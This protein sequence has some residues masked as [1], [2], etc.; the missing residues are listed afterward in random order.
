MRHSLHLPK[1]DLCK[2]DGAG[3]SAW[4]VMLSQSEKMCLAAYGQQWGQG[5]ILLQSPGSPFGTPKPGSGRIVLVRTGAAEGHRE[6]L[7]LGVK[8]DP[9]S[10][11]GR[12][13]GSKA[14]ELVMDVKVSITPGLLV[15]ILPPYEKVP[16]HTMPCQMR[17]QAAASEEL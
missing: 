13:Q 9:L 10:T 12:V 11:L 2:G 4:S 8:D 1:A 17:I 14:A 3:E 16:P 15:S 7:L 5:D 6:G